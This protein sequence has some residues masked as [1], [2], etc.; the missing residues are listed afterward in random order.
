VALPLIPQ[1]TVGLTLAVTIAADPVFQLVSVNP[2]R[3]L[4]VFGAGI[5]DGVRIKQFQCNGG[6]NQKWRMH[7]MSTDGLPCSDGVVDQVR[8]VRGACAL[9]RPLSLAESSG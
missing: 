5:G 9:S 1:W 8:R 6:S 4:E 3:R 2:G 7:L